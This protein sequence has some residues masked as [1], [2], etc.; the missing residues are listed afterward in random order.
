LLRGKAWNPPTLSAF[1]SQGALGAIT[2]TVWGILSAAAKAIPLNFKLWSINVIQGQPMMVLTHVSWQFNTACYLA[3]AGIP[4]F[5]QSVQYQFLLLVPI[6]V[7]EAYA[8]KKILNL[9]VTKAASLASLVN[10]ISTLGGGFLILCFGALIGQILFGSTVP[11]QPGDFPFL[12]IEIMITLVPM[13]FATVALESFIGKFLLK[14]FKYHDVKRSFA[15]AN[16]LTYGMLEMLA[17][18]QLIHGYIQGRG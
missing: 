14:K 16:V 10:V 6:I 7:I 18:T 2:I 8:H 11:V 13:Y 12:P 9:T 5:T 3:N 4:L 15:I 1:S 17:I